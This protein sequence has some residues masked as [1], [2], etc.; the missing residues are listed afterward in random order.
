MLIDIH[1]LILGGFHK[2]VMRGVSCTVVESTDRAA[3]RKWGRRVPL[4]GELLWKVGYRA[5]HL[6]QGISQHDAV[7][8]C[9]R[10]IDYELCCG[11]DVASNWIVCTESD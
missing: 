6:H 11:F 7:D 1:P 2:A 5:V 10:G 9:M 3:A 8:G 4:K